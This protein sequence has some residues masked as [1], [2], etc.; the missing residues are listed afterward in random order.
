MVVVA[1]APAKL[2]LSLRVTGVR[3][4]GYH[5]LESEMITLA[6]LHDTIELGPGDGF[7]LL[8]EPLASIAVQDN[9]VVRALGLLGR[10]ALVRLTKRIPVGAGLG[11]GSSDAA[12]VLRWG[13]VVPSG[14]PE[15]PA[16]ALAARLGADVPFC[17]VGGR[18]RVSGIGEVVEPLVPRPL[19]IALVTPPF[20]VSTPAVYAAWDRLGG[21][22]GEGR[23]DLEVAAVSVEPRL[24]AWRDAL[25][26]STGCDPILAGSGSSWFVEL[27]SQKEAD[28]LV[29]LTLEVAGGRSKVN[30]LSAEMEQLSP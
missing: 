16:L 2:T 18:A 27:G 20:G 1:R 4:D 14:E 8:G 19:L 28:Q 23:N 3:P 13:G 21:P 5:L 9:L 12:A 10:T 11:G 24:A 6:G 26:E 29:G 30:L 25:G 7:E 22:V 15:D 17:L